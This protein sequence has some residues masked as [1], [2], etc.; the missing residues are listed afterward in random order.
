MMDSPWNGNG[1]QGHPIQSGNDDVFQ[2]LDMNGMDG[3]GDG[4]PF[5][6]S[7]FNGNGGSNHMTPDLSRDMMD[8]PMTGTDSNM[9]LSRTDGLHHD[10]SSIG[11]GV[12]F[13]SLPGSTLMSSPASTGAIVNSI[14]AQIQFLQQQKLEHQQRELQARQ[15]AF[16]AQHIPP[17]PTSL[18][19][20][21][22]AQHYYASPHSQSEHTPQHQSL[23][24]RFHQSRE[25][26]EMSFTPLV[27]PAVTPLETHFPIDT[28]FTVPGAYFSPLTSPALHAQNEDSSVG[29]GHMHSNGSSPAKL[30]GD[31]PVAPS[32]LMGTPTDTYSEKVKK[33]RKPTNSR[34]KSGFRQSPMVKAQRKKSGA[35]PVMVEQAP[36]EGT[37]QSQ[38]QQ[39]LPLPALPESS[40]LSLGASTDSDHNSSVSPQDLNDSSMDMPPPP[41]PKK[42]RSGNPSPYLAARHH[43]HDL[44]H[45]GMP[46]PATPASLMKLSSPSNQA[47]TGSNGAH[48]PM[49]AEL[50]ENFELPES[51]SF[52]KAQQATPQTET[53][54]GTHAA[55][56]S[57]AEAGFAPSP[58]TQPMPS[59]MF[60][61]T[62]AAAA[63][64][65]SDTRS[66]QL[67]PGSGSLSEKKTPLLAARSSKKRSS[68]SGVTVH[69]SPALRPKISPNIKPLLPGGASAEETASHILATKSNYQRILE[70]NTVGGV[71]Y[72]SSLST[73][74][75]SKRTSH[76]IAEQ[77]RR[78]RM[79]MGLVELA[80]LLPPK[81]GSAKEKE[82]KEST[83]G[84]EDG[85]S[86][87]KKDKNG[88]VPNSKAE[89]V[90][91][92]IEYIKQLQK[93]LAEANRRAED[94][95]K[96]AETA[97]G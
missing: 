44:A 33:L 66:P 80:S 20:V 75:T 49:T 91:L 64:P 27:S 24:Y 63:A 65:G 15:A 4:L 51:A 86:N 40:R 61:R 82:I 39:T 69:V 83:E 2:F 32:G 9:V 28:Q 19:L 85:E 70:G 59:P 29:F 62:A 45:L 87:E 36:Q 78:N 41:K 52:P 54:N 1:Q 95:S 93:E 16:L 53:K 25:Q 73:N 34:S 17:T 94:A 18:E 10:I 57:S 43:A 56:T 46:P 77:G 30:D 6:F 14:E 89:T 26:Q 21:P 42:A 35:T 88:N 55:K 71:S 12:S 50:I 5:N 22:G 68:V 72:P 48:E 74:L 81:T 38:E 97:D 11:S 76:K 7:D 31:G 3:L 67:T 60:A 90:E 13:P 79:N 96:K 84:E 92:A 58:A 37:D 23:D 47:S 8:T